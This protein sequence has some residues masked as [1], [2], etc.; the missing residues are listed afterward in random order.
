MQ[1]KL[2]SA[3]TSR[4]KVQQLIANITW[5][6]KEVETNKEHIIKPTVVQ[7]YLLAAKEHLEKEIKMLDPNWLN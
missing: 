1:E 3:I 4:E 5:A 2:N 6:M 7:T